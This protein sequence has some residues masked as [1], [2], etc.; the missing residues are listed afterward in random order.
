MGGTYALKLMDTK[1]PS[2]LTKCGKTML[3]LGLSG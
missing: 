2:W 3:A 1:S